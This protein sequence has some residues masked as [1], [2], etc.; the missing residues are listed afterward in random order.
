MH[1]T[2]AARLVA[3]TIAV[4]VIALLNYTF[5]FRW[6]ALGVGALVFI[7]VPGLIGFVLGISDRRAAF[8][9]TGGRAPRN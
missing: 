4:A 9:K 3:F 8:K 5:G 6:Y 7:T 1:R 2:S